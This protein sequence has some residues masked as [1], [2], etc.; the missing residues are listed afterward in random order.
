MPTAT[1]EA[2]QA[3]AAAELVTDQAAAHITA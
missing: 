1:R 3:L 2:E